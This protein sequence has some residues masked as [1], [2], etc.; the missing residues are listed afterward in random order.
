[1]RDSERQQ[2]VVTTM[3]EELKDLDAEIR[4]RID[5]QHRNM[6]VLVVILTAV[7]GFLMKYVSENGLAALAVSELVVLIAMVPFIIN[8]FLWRHLDHDVNIIDKASYIHGVLRPRVAAQLGGAEVL[9]FESHLH[10]RRQTRSRRFGPFLNVG[11]EDLPMFLFLGIYL[12]SG[13]YIRTQSGGHAGSAHAVFDAFLYLG[14]LLSLLSVLMAVGV[15]NE[16]RKVGG[17]ADSPPR[18]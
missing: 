3:L 6:N 5:L 1:M 4:L 8:V 9:D 12:L 18:N 17:P 14:T 16:Y 2:L 11:K 7:T 10:A 15:G 13:W